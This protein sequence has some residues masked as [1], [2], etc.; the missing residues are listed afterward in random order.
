MVPGAERR[1]QTLQPPDMVKE[2]LAFLQ[3]SVDFELATEGRRI[4]PLWFGHH[5]IAGVY[6]DYLLTSV[7]RLLEDV[8]VDYVKEA[9][10]LAADRPFDA[11]QLVQ[12]GLEACHKLTHH[13]QAV[14]QVAENLRSLER[15]I[16]EHDWPK[17]NAE[18]TAGAIQSL[19][20]ELVSTLVRLSPTLP[21]SFNAE[22]S[23][24]D[25]GYLY[26]T[27]AEET[28]RKMLIG[29]PAVMA[30]FPAYF[31]SALSAHNRV[32][33][34]LAALPDRTRIAFSSD[35]LADL[36]DISA[37]ALIMS[38]L[39]LPQPWKVVEATWDTYLK[40]SPKPVE[41]LKLLTGS[42]SFLD[43]LFAVTP[44]TVV[45]TGWRRLFE[46]HVVA[47]GM[48]TR[49]SYSF[50]HRLNANTGGALAQAFLEH[51]LHGA[52]DVFVGAYLAKHPAFVGVE[53]PRAVRNFDRTLQA[54]A[55][56]R[57]ENPTDEG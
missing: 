20:D 41:F 23:P 36:C 14:A 43:N 12:S 40:A 27:L 32:R 24:D 54:V 52:H 26:V 4:T 35:I 29:S 21:H 45:R 10:R 18:A 30:M 37:Y 56:R 47:Q 13:T 3:R 5:F 25:F 8:R 39:G 6:L 34:E 7:N 9:A 49:G 16:A 57:T 31:A 17:P 15:P 42:L 44:R 38:D 33:Q 22:D 2:K 53:I 19:C 1:P 28:L 11:F 46:E 50:A 48:A 51:S 55:K